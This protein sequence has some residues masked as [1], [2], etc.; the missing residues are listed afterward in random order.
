MQLHGPQIVSTV[1][2]SHLW[3]R[4][5]SKDSFQCLN[6]SDYVD[7]AAEEAV[8]LRDVREQLGKS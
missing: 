6:R 1:A 4:R 8:Q 7:P 2:Q 5:R 3:M